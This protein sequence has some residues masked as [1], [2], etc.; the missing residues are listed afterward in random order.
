MLVRVMVGVMLLGCWVAAEE[1]RPH[2]WPSYAQFS[3]KEIE[4][5]AA[6]VRRSR[7]PMHRGGWEWDRLLSRYLDSGRRDR[8][9]LRILRAYFLSMLDRYDEATQAGNEITLFE[10]HRSWGSGGRLRVFAELVRQ[11]AITPEEQKRFEELVLRS[12]KENFP[13]YRKMERGVNNRP[14]GIHGGPA[15]AARLFPHHPHSKR[16]QPWLNALW[17]ELEEYGDTT[18]TNY[19]PYGPLYLHGLLDIAEGMGKLEKRNDR[20]FLHTHFR[21]YL[22]YVHGGGVRG[23]PNSESRVIP[24]QREKIYRDPW[25]AEY[26]SGAERVNDGHVWYRVAKEYRDPEFLWASEQA[27]LGGRPPKGIPIPPEY[28]KA[29]EQRYFWFTDRGIE[30]KVPAGGAK[31]G[32]YSPLKHRVPERLYLGPSRESGKPFVSFYIYDR[33][34]NYMHYCDDSDGKLYEYSVDGAKFLHTSG[35]YTS[36]RAGVG[37]GSYDMLTVLP[38]DM[39]FP[40]QEG[41]GMDNPTGEAW[42]MASMSIKVTLPCREGPDSKNWAFDEE[43]GLFRRTDEPE[44]GYSH[45]NM[46]GYWYLN[47]E[48]HLTSLRIGDF[49]AGTQVQNLRLSGPAGE[50]I[51]AAFDRLGDD[52][53]VELVQGAQRHKLEGR[54][55]QEAFRIVEGGRRQGKCLEVG[56]IGPTAR[57][58]I[59]VKNLDLKFDGQNE[60]TRMSYDF[61]GQGGGITPNVRT[62]PSYFTSL[63]HRGAILERKNLKAENKGEDSF[64]QFTM[65]NYYGAN[66]SWTRQSVLTAEG[67]LVVRDSYLPC[68]DVDHYQAAPCWLIVAE[69]PRVAGQNWFHAPARDYAWWQSQKKRVLLYLHPQEGLEIGQ[70]QHR[71]SQ[72]HAGDVRNS[73][74]RATLTAGKAQVWL[75]VLRPFNQ[76]QSPKALAKTI[77]TRVDDRGNASASIGSLNVTIGVGGDWAVTR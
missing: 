35:K 16:H 19:Y 45:G 17:R 11:K 50:K 55:R 30:P 7:P 29:Y 51:L 63:W 77:K 9:E 25:N 65:R 42:K 67:Y 34:N 40:M 2:P 60:Y 53:I 22:D 6:K 4:E 41:S 31:I 15:I 5:I 69:G 20:D 57:L 32:S 10:G 23:N 71:T 43:V 26:Y 28:L 54:M 56:N 44:L 59:T 58:S 70:V 18:E 1:E 48:Y 66:S 68:S 13:D 3:G 37:E 27:T 76:G 52:V 36:G 24:N 75:S 12:L 38:P 21:R 39:K 14:Y 72:G 62:N 61:K 49:P 46:D 74:A 33:N 8:N 64:G 47:N 73:F